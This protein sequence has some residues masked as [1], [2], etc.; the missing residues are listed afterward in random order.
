[1]KLHSLWTYEASVW[2]VLKWYVTSNQVSNELDGGTT[3]HVKARVN[4]YVI[5]LLI[6]VILAILPA[7]MWA[8]MAMPMKDNWEN[9]YWKGQPHP[10]PEFSLQNP[11]TLF[12]VEMS[13]YKMLSI[14][15]G[16][17]RRTATGFPTI[18]SSLWLT[19]HLESAGFPPL[20]MAIEHFAWATPLWFCLLVIIYELGRFTR[21]RVRAH[22][23]PPSN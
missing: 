3:I 9:W 2:R 7:A 8:D 18:Y 10:R 20:A 22:G 23:S 16:Y 21:S 13:A 12:R 15:P 14:P 1:M 17:L 4:P 5:A 6:A 11:P 19:P